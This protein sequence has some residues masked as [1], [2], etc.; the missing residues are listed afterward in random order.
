MAAMKCIVLLFHFLVIRLW[1]IFNSLHC[2][3]VSN[4]WSVFYP[5]HKTIEP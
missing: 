3:F 5:M 2:F 4:D 1:Y